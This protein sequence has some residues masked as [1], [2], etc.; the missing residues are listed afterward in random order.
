MLC[1]LT[2]SHRSVK[3]F[4][5]YSNWSIKCDGPLIV[6]RASKLP[7]NSYLTVPIIWP[8]SQSIDEMTIYKTI[9]S[10][11]VFWQELAVVART[12]EAAYDAFEAYLQTNKSMA[13]EEI[14]YKGALAGLDE[15]DVCCERELYVYSIGVIEPVLYHTLESWYIGLKVEVI[16]SG[17]NDGNK[18]L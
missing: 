11:T 8:N 5:P 13:K 4:L 18:P 6:H 17:R 12:R 15:A 14:E 3:I 7:E 9:A 2:N 1:M 16:A 10:N